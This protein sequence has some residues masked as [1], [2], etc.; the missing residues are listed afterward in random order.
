MRPNAKRATEE[1]TNLAVG[2]LSIIQF[3]RDKCFS[4]SA[5]E[6]SPVRTEMRSWEPVILGVNWTAVGFSQLLHT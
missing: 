4:A 3:P 2:F 5:R 1:Q 6:L